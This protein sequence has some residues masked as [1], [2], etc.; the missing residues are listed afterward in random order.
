[1]VKLKAA[2]QELL[3]NL[4]KAVNPYKVL[5]INYDSSK[6]EVKQKFKEKMKE[7]R[8]DY[9][10]RADLCLADDIILNKQFYK[11]SPKDFFYFDPNIK[12]GK[13][14]CHYYAVIGDTIKF[15]HLVMNTIE[16]KDLIYFKDPSDR[17]LLYLAA[18]NG[19]VDLC[20]LIINFGFYDI[21]DTQYTGST[22]LH[23]AAYYG[24][25]DVVQLLLNYG[26]RTDIKNKFGNLPKD[27]AMTEEIKNILEEN[28]KDRIDIMY[29]SLLSKNIATNIIPLYSHGEII[30]RKIICK[31]NNLPEKYDIGEVA[32]NWITAWH[33]TRFKNLE[34]IAEVGLKPAGGKTK[35]GKE[36]KVEA[37]H[38]DRDYTMGSVPNWGEAIFVSP[39]IFYCSH[40][41]YSKEIVSSNETWKIFVEVRVKPKSYLEHGSTVRNYS[42]KEGE[43]KYLEYRIE[44][45]NEKDVQVVSLTFV[46]G[47]L[48]KNIQK[49]DEAN[50]LNF[51][52]PKEDY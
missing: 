24:Q 47:E 12:E 35:Q 17:N 6:Y 51:K 10:A 8:N 7:V 48:F 5:G 4:N 41:A 3:E 43:P 52:F 42:Y 19:H 36:I 49:F 50:F 37:G 30:A 27:E 44:P 33:G 40:P 45:K 25:K 28:E 34:S 23:A 18:R 16:K 22:P 26:A 32:D 29:K 46:K 11:E 38:I 1:M 13:N 2:V 20:E 14:L 31:L 39:S 21:N 15:A 9:S